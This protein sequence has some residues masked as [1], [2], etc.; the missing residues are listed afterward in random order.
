[1]GEIGSDERRMCLS[2]GHGGSRDAGGQVV[3]ELFIYHAVLPVQLILYASR[4]SARE[5]SPAQQ[6]THNH[7]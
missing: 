3:S 6:Y 4:H 7:T 2:E 1:M 5:D